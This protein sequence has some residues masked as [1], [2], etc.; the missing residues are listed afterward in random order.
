VRQ[1]RLETRKRELADLVA[2]S[3]MIF[4]DIE[5]AEVFAHLRQRLRAE[6]N[7]IPDHD[8]W[9]AATAIRHDLTLITRDRHFERI[10]DLRRA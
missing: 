9:I 8:I 7:L 5:T 6:G 1:P 2:A 3:T 10:P 4:L